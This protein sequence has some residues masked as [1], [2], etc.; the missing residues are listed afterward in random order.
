M[1][2]YLK[3]LRV[4]GDNL[5]GDEVT[6]ADSFFRQVSLYITIAVSGVT[7]QEQSGIQR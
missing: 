7:G 3:Q 5:L 6:Q 4:L 1:K 2:H